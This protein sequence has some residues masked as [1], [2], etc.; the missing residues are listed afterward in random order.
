M[1]VRNPFVA[2]LLRLGQSSKKSDRVP[3]TWMPTT[4][5]V[6]TISEHPKVQPMRWMM[7]ASEPTGESAKP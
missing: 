5:L 4:A 2:R 1:L 6:S 3:K 7:T